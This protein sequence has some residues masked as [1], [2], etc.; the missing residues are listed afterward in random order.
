M[1]FST[2]KLPSPKMV[3]TTSHDI[4]G[5]DVLGSKSRVTVFVACW[6]KD[7]VTPIQSF[8]YGFIAN[9]CLLPCEASSFPGKQDVVCNSTGEVH[10]HED[11]LLIYSSPGFPEGNMTSDQE[12]GLLF[13]PWERE[14]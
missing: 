8:C 11:P 1:V 13:D 3:Y 5:N 10:I 12:L 9:S 2:S 4:K 7:R 6:W 14:T